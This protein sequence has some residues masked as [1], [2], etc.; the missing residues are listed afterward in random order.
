MQTATDN[1]NP[2]PNPNPNDEPP[3]RTFT[4][5]LPVKLS[6]DELQQYGKMLADKVK[7]EELAEDR[8]KQVVAAHANGIKDIRIEIKRIADA[9]AK[10]QELRPVKC[11]ERLRNGVI[12]IVRLDTNEVVDVRPADLRD[13]QT[14]IPGTGDDDDDFDP[15]GEAGP[16]GERFDMIEPRESPGEMTTSSTGG[17]VFVGGTNANDDGTD[18][19]ELDDEFDDSDVPPDSD[20]SLEH[21]VESSV[22]AGDP[23]DDEERETD[24]FDDGPAAGSTSRARPQRPPRGNGK[25]S[26]KPAAKKST[27]RKR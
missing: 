17:Q 8:K 5:E 21:A 7:E 22:E 14:T 15:P 2:N 10:G 3:L 4:R 9:R 25:A 6:E 1:T 20:S 12:E 23:R 19:D 18:L 24:P 26:G 13:L 27:K 16:K 11:H